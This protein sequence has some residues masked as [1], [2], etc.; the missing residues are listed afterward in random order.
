MYNDISSSQANVCDKVGWTDVLCMMPAPDDIGSAVLC[1]CA[2]DDLESDPH[3]AVGPL[4][5]TFTRRSQQLL[6][7]DLPLCEMRTS[8]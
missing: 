6:T 2:R 5:H 8:G 7:N 3:C 4:L 1:Q